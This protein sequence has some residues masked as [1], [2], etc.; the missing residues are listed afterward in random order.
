MNGQI[1]LEE[2]IKLII[3]LPVI[4]VLFS[5]L[6]HTVNQFQNIGCEKYINEINNLRSEIRQLKA[7]LNEKDYEI[8]KLNS[9]LSPLNKSLDEKDKLIA[10][11]T[12]ELNKTKRENEIL[13]KEINY[14]EEKKYITEI[15]NYFMNVSNQLTRIENRFLMIEFSIGLLSFSLLTFIEI[16]LR[17]GR[18]FWRWIKKLL[19]TKKKGDS[20]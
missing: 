17:P 20:P 16:T 7:Q 10:N 6:F 4:F 1:D 13:K 15:H 12:A 2:L 19:K 5:V 11:L 3:L 9:L 14:Y 8:T 18:K